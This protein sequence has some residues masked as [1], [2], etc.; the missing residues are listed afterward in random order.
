MF[1]PK[2][3]L[4][5]NSPFFFLEFCSSV[6]QSFLVFDA[7][8]SVGRRYYRAFQKVGVIEEEG[9]IWM[10]NRGEWRWQELQGR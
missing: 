5:I 7:N 10:V 6:H 1:Y 8:R 2:G 4:A 3:T 9:H